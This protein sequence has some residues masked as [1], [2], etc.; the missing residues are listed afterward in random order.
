MG[1]IHIESREG[2]LHGQVRATCSK[3]V[4]KP[5]AICYHQ[6]SSQMRSLGL[7]RLDDT[8]S[9]QHDDRLV[10]SCCQQT[11]CNADVNRLAA[12]CRQP[13]CCDADVNRPAAICRQPTCCDADVN[14]PAAICCQQACCDAG[15][16][17]IC[18]KA[19][20]T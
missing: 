11:C 3:S 5:H 6:A 2:F 12:I 17:Q 14:R 8:C 19:Q 10:A 15:C 13:T 7:L 18:C 20:L 9:H 4:V 1:S 16:E